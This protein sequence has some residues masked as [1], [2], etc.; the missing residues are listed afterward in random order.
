MRHHSAGA[1][2]LLTPLQPAHNLVVNTMNRRGQ[3]LVKDARSTVADD[4][5]AIGE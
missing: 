4:N 1:P 2:A 3:G 5:V